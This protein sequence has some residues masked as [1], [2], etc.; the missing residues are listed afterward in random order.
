[1]RTF[2]DTNVLVYLFDGDAPEKQGRARAMLQ[3]CVDEGTLVLSTQVLQ[4][5]HVAVSRKLAVP[6]DLPEA[7]Q[8]LESLVRLPV[9]PVDPPMVLAA[10]RLARAHTLCFWDA[11]IV[12]AALAA[13]ATRLL[14]EDLQA[15]RRFGELEVVDPFVAA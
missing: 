12:E 7:E 8:A 2:F 15:G 14:S 1:M 9:I 6:L 10:A 4:E 13:G 11:L 3:E 5:F